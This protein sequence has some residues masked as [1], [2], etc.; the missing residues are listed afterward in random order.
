MLS[1]KKYIAHTLGKDIRSKDV[2]PNAPK[3]L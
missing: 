2:P 3:N 1:S